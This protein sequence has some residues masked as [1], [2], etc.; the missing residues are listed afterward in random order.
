MQLTYSFIIPVYNRPE[1]IEELLESFSKM[2]FA[3]IKYEIIIVEDGSTQTA[4]EIA[5]NYTNR[6]CLKYFQKENSGA[7]DSRNYGMRQAEGD[8]FIIL[9]SDVI[10]PK[11]YLKNVNQHLEKN[12]VD[13][14]GGADA[15]H[16]DFT[17]LQK[18]INFSMTSFLTTGGIRGKEKSVEKFK[19]R[20][21]NM[22]FSRKVFE[23]TGGYAKIKVGEDLDLSIR[24]AKEG[25][26]IAYIPTA[27]VYHK[28]RSTWQKFYKQVNKFGMGRPILSRWYPETSS[29]F[30]ALPTLFI[31]G[32]FFA[33][34]ALLFKVYLPIC[35]YIFYFILIFVSSILTYKSFKIALMSVLATLI[36][37]FG[38]GLG[39]L[40]S[41]F[42]IKLLSKKPEDIF[43]ELFCS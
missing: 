12:Y 34:F 16:E 25:F 1:E 14:F 22:G 17:P 2:I 26:I 27:K 8:Y 38:Y 20:S 23:K 11:D 29:L 42:Y 41:M 39:Y 24:I 32:L 37:F 9:D 7:G 35:I 6:L 13:C 36:Q 3:D 43:P 10:L 18:A 19:P 21:F 33:L 15:A 5:N 31:I 40:K 28:R 4:E 30:F